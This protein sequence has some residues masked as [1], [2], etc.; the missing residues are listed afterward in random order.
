MIKT[1][2]FMAAAGLLSLWLSP[3][4]GAVL[5]YNEATGGDL[6]AL[7]TEAPIFALGVGANTITGQMKFA[8][9]GANDFD[10]FR[11]QVADSERLDSILVSIALGETSGSGIFDEAQYYLRDAV[12][13]ILGPLQR[14]LIP[15]TNVSLFSSLLPF[16]GPGVLAFDHILV[17]GGGA[18]EY[19]AYANYTFTLNVSAVAVPEPMTVGLLG[20]GLAGIGAVRRRRIVS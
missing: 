4:Q 15:S 2:I 12:F 18:D 7:V 5:S 20:L 8:V 3:A 6:A 1:S 17:T 13:S 16:V 14:I 19:Y 10:S 11:V 9:D